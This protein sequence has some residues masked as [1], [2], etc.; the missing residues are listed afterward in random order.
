MKICFWGNIGG[1]LKGETDGGGELQLALLAKALAKGGHEVVIID[2]EA[3]ENYITADGIKVFKIDGW[4]KGIRI[5]RSL[6]HR[7]PQLYR[8]LKAQKAEVYYCRIRDFRHILAF[9]AAR[10]VKAKFVLGL[11]SDLDAMNFAKRFRYQ[12]LVSVKDL[13]AFSSGI[14]IEIV[15]PFLL[16]KADLVLTQHQG[17]KNILEKKGI[18]SSIFPNLIDLSNLPIESESVRKDFI[19]I[20]WL[21][22]RKGFPEFFE[23]VK[24]C[25]AQKFK[26]IGPPCD[27]D[28]FLFYKKLKTFNNVTLLGKLSHPM[29]LKNITS[30]QALISTSQMEGFPNVFI[31][32]WACGIPVLSLYID[33]GDTIK[34]EN[35][36]I[37]ADGNHAKLIRAISS[38]EYSNESAKKAKDYVAR[39]HVLNTNKIKEISVLFTD[40]K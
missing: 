20:G 29:V 15:Y 19:Y 12:H 16:R 33:P 25:P 39:N 38:N 24:K 26:I 2:Y 6:T 18:K 40:L 7:L 21:S 32:A 10:K 9:W 37:V 34:R 4:N 36:G 5:I 23:I 11:A 31:E 14:L 27:K 3:K 22:K 17:Q 28:G 35:L 1:A 8:S 13:W 30:S